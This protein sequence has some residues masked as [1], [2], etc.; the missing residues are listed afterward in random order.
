[1]FTAL[2]IIMKSTEEA[3]RAAISQ[4]LGA[5]QLRMK[6]HS[7]HLPL[8]FLLLE[9]LELCLF[10]FLQFHTSLVYL[11]EDHLQLLLRCDS[12]PYF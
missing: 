2:V 9:M 4:T 8:V 7:F 5:L 6:G 3:L 1:M 12:L 11:L 10:T